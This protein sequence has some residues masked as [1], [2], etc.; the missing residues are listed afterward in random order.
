MKMR[1]FWHHREK[2]SQL[3][4]RQNRA[5]GGAL[6]LCRAAHHEQAAVATASARGLSMSAAKRAKF[7]RWHRPFLDEL[8]DGERYC[9]ALACAACVASSAGIDRCSGDGTHWLDASNETTTSAT[10]ARSMACASCNG[11]EGAPA[12]VVVH[13][14]RHRRHA[15][16]MWLAAGIEA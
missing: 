5:A 11:G 3:C 2:A 14:R 8:S 10:S 7:A 1:L 6:T 12:I 15:T 13:N 16:G 4:A 9:E